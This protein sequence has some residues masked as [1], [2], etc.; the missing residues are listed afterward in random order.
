MEKT[1]K[2]RIGLDAWRELEIVTT[3]YGNVLF[4]IRDQEE[5]SMGLYLGAKKVR[6]IIEQLERWEKGIGF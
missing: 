6:E 3:Y 1:K 2:Y 5:R 4:Q